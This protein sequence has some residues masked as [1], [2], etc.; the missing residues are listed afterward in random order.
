[1]RERGKESTC[2]NQSDKSRGMFRRQ[3]GE[4]R[5][6]APMSDQRVEDLLEQAMV[7]CALKEEE[8]VDRWR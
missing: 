3:A 6:R 4:P 1:M 2:N 5:R 7:E 8:E